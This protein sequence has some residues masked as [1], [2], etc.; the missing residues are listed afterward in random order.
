MSGFV[1]P[2]PELV[3]CFSARRCDRGGRAV[4][5]TFQVRGLADD[6][7]SL[8]FRRTGSSSTAAIRHLHSIRSRDLE[9]A[10][11]PRTSIV[12]SRDL[13]LASS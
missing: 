1:G 10:P 7:F 8:S 12:S 11:N 4:V 13:S 5:E 3:L 9:A 6:E 2:S